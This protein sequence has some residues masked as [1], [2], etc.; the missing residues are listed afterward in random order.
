PPAA[1]RPVAVAVRPTA[2]P[3]RCPGTPRSPDRARSGCVPADSCP[4]RLRL[5]PQLPQSGQL[6]VQVA[7]SLLPLR[8]G[9]SGRLGG[10]AQRLLVGPLQ[11]LSQPGVVVPQLSLDLAQGVPGMF[12]HDE[13]DLVAVAAYRVAG[14][15][16]PAGPL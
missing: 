5:R 6:G 10:A 14:L 3:R 13:A 2:W 12:T 15:L 9:A 4:Y 16:L 8:L 7:Q 11:F 1:A